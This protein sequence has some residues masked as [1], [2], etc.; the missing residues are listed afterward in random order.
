MIRYNITVDVLTSNQEIW[1]ID[2]LVTAKNFK[3]AYKKTTAA[4]KK[5]FGKSYKKIL[6][7]GGYV[8][9]YY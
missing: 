6:E 8:I 5:Q 4:M 9:G 2:H 3:D 7:R 1:H